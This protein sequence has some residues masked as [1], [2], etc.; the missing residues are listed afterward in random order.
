MITRDL[1]CPSHDYCLYN[2]Q[3]DARTLIGPSAM[4]YCA[5]KHMEISRVFWIII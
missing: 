3:M 4:V 1:E 5:S 2:N